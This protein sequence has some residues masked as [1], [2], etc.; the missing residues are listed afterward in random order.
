MKFNDK[1][2]RCQNVILVQSGADS[3]QAGRPITKEELFAFTGDPIGSV[4]LTVIE[5]RPLSLDE[6]NGW[7][8]LFGSWPE[9][10]DEDQALDEIYHA[11]SAASSSPRE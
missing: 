8:A 11:R 10:G 3:C 6:K 5:S 9:N 2:L 1:E 7:K 4:S